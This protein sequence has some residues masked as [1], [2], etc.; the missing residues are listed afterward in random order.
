MKRRTLKKREARYWRSQRNHWKRVR[1][2][3]DVWV[4]LQAA[5][6]SSIAKITFTV[7]EVGGRDGS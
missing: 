1:G 3:H 7:R 4:S 6:G 5:D 2:N